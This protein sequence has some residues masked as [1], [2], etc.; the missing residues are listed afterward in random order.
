MS[1]E[2]GHYRIRQ[3][4]GSGGM[5]EVYLAEDLKLRRTVALKVLLPDV[6]Q[7]PSRRSRFWLE[8]CRAPFRLAR[9]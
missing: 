2:I 8:M 4:L 7:D 9:R 6:A 5:G 3:K 1:D